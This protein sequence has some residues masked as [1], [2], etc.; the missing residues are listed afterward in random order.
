MVIIAMVPTSNI[1][2]AR[3]EFFLIA[4]NVTGTYRTATVR[5]NTPSMSAIC[6]LASQ[7]YMAAAA[8]ANPSNIPIKNFLSILDSGF[9]EDSIFLSRLQFCDFNVVLI[10]DSDSLHGKRKS[11]D[12]EGDKI[13]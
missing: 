4:Q 8:I 6:D 2:K 3:L 7:A 12:I 9:L 11:L 10:L 1:A 5:K 13:M